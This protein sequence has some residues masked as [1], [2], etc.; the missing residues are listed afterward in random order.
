M[1]FKSGLKLMQLAALAAVLTG[2]TSCASM[3]GNKNCHCTHPGPCICCDM[4]MATIMAIRQS[5]NLSTHPTSRD[6]AAE[7]SI[8]NELLDLSKYELKSY[9]PEEPKRLVWQDDSITVP[10]DSLMPKVKNGQLGMMPWGVS[11]DNT[12]NAIYLYFKEDADGRP[13][14]LRL[15]IQ[16]YA[17]DPLNFYEAEFSINGFEYHF[18]PS[19]FQRGKSGGKMIWENSDDVV[20]VADKDL[21]YALAHCDWAILKLLA[22]NG[23]NHNKQLSDEQLAH[24]RNML[25]LYLL[26]GGKIE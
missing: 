25:N 13:E 26:K 23:I 21:I 9:L 7:D 5:L 11:T 18:K 16:Y 19:N 6:S 3:F 22:P 14:P 24:F 4:D 17:D 15:R 10:V 8:L 20:T 2:A 12:E 1:K